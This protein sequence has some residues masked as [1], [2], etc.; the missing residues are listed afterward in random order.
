[1]EFVNH[2]PFPALAF[3]GV[4]QHDQ[5]FHVVVLRQTF[6]LTEDG[7]L[8]A[9]EQSPLSVED[10]WF[11]EPGRSGVREESDL[12]QFK[13]K[14]DVIVN[15][16]AYSPASRAMGRFRVGLVVRAPDAPE[17]ALPASPQG[18]NPLLP[19]SPA[20]MAQWEQECAAV[21]GVTQSGVTLIDKV[22]DVTGERVLVRSAFA[23][24]WL[25]RICRG[26]TLGLMRPVPWSLSRPVP[27]R[28]IPL[29]PELAFGGE[30][31][32]SAGSPVAAR[33]PQRHRFP[34]AQGDMGP[35]AHT[36]FPENPIGA[37]WSE[38][39]Y[40]DAAQI[41]TL[42]APQ[43]EWP[44][45]PFDL[46]VFEQ[47]ISGRPLPKQQRVACLGVRAKGHPERAKLVG[48][49]DE[50][51]VASSRWLPDDF[52]FSVWNAAPP[53]QQIAYPQGAEV[54]ELTNLFPA[55]ATG[56]TL[57][58]QGNSMM[59]FALP[60]HL[61]FVRVRLE[62]GAWFRLPMNIDTVSID[63]ERRQLCLVWRRIVAK[64]REAPIRVLE[65]GILSA[66]QRR[67]R[68]RLFTEFDAQARRMEARYA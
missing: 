5:Q 52:D 45:A 57:D 19:P 53:D 33:V 64:T 37:G 29:R 31:R 23:T 1:M 18:L 55:D 8:Y 14:C 3:E 22:L 42:K 12:C 48:T 4:D 38:G 30:C 15:G 65:A 9:D 47:A 11:G 10:T 63:T 56:V 35:V 16:A 51:F 43:F 24:S 68:E 41:K 34:D 61:A 62:S 17:R 36:A 20:A 21:R 27:C 40:L 58:D 7:P 2:T 49:I 66:A 67:E 32:V 44:D 6:D 25:A 13:P 59:R 28:S 60:E 26:L 50:S 39:W 54:F 46:S